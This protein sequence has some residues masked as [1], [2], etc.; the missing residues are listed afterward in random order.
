M[1]AMPVFM[2]RACAPCPFLCVCLCDFVV[3][4]VVCVLCVCLSVFVVCVLRL[5]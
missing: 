4:C 3:V 2:Y 5:L 1:S